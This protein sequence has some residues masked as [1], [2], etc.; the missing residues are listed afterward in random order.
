MR[1]A[2]IH[3]DYRFG[4]LHL[5]SANSD[6]R[7]EGN[8]KACRPLARIHFGRKTGPRSACCAR[9]AES[10]GEPEPCGTRSEEHTS[11]LQSHSELVCRLLLEKKKARPPS[12][13]CR[14]S[15]RPWDA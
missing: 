10:R 8:H 5:G 7:A 12:R 4:L 11:E 1:F 13:P 6:V 2:Q 3:I 14:R 9:P 15:T